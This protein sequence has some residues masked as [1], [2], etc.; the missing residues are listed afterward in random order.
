VFE[1][2]YHVLSREYRVFMDV[3]QAVNLAIVRA[4]ASHGISLAYPTQ[5]LLLRTET[6]LAAAARRGDG[7]ENKE[8]SPAGGP[9]Q[10]LLRGTAARQR[11]A[12]LA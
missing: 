6:G 10:P 8:D 5:T 9:G 11:N 7:A 12:S 2:V 3:H 1:A 4:F